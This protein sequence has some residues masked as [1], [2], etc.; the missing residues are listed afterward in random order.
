MTK[1]VEAWIQDRQK[2]G[3]E[4]RPVSHRHC[5]QRRQRRGA[6]G[7]DDLE[8]VLGV[9]TALESGTEDQ[10]VTGAFPF[11]VHVPDR[12]PDERIHPVKAAGQ[13]DHEL[14]EAVTPLH[15][16]QP[17]KQDHPAASIGPL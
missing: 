3:L 8:Q 6:Q 16:C 9:I 11:D 17:V 12:D 2:S 14:N 1:A 10:A 5:G 13:P 7:P 4:M 15:V